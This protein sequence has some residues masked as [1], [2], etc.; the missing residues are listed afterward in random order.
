VPEPT[1]SDTLIVEPLSPQFITAMHD[2]MVIPE[3][4]DS[5]ASSA[6]LEAEDDDSDLYSM[7]NFTV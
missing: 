6:P 5:D 3:I 4:S 2:T 1:Q 7:R